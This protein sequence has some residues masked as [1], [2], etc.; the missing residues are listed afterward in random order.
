MGL[1]GSGKSWFAAH[2]HNPDNKY[3]AYAKENTVTIIDVDELRQK[4]KSEEYTKKLNSRADQYGTVILDG[5]FLTKQDLKDLTTSLKSLWNRV[6]NIEIDYWYPDVKTCLYND[7]YRRD[8]NSEATIR[9]AKMELPD[10]DSLSD[11]HAQQVL[12]KFHT[13][14]KK[15]EWKYKADDLKL[16]LKDDEYLISDCWITGGCIRD[17]KGN[18][19]FVEAESA[20]DSFEKFDELLEKICPNLPFTAYLS[21]KENCVTV[22][23]TYEN[24][25]YGG[26]ISKS[27]YQCDIPKLFEK[28]EEMKYLKK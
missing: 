14:K 27:H 17:Y 16:A 2:Y 4:Y 26:E 13:V 3:S 6:A 22:E 10:L 1:P 24:D 25:Y 19:S 12:I 8:K 21:L 18:T 11:F 20:P 5:L 15:P 9:A 23:D 7:R 28:L